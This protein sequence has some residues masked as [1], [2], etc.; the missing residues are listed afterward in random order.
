MVNPQGCSQ[1]ITRCAFFLLT[2]LLLSAVANAEP[3]IALSKKSGPPTSRILVSGRGFEANVGVDIFFDTKN[4]ALVVTN[5]K[6]EFHDAAINAPRSAHPGE[7]W[8]TALE[9]NNDT[10]ARAPFLVRTNWQQFQFDNDHSSVNPFENVISRMNVASLT[11]KWVYTSG[12]GLV[13][14]TPTVANGIAYVTAIGLYAVDTKTGAL[15]WS[16]EA[17]S[18]TFFCSPAVVDG[19]LYVASPDGYFYALNAD[20]GA[21]IWKV[22]G[23]SYNGDTAPAVSSGIVYYGGNQ[24]IYAVN[25]KTGKVVWT[26]PTGSYTR[27]AP[28]VVDGI[29][30]AGSNDGN[31][32]ALDARKG[33][34]VWRAAIGL[35]D[36]SSPAVAEGAVFVG[37]Y[38]GTFYALD[39]STG[40][41]LWSFPTTQN[42]E[43]SPLVNNGLV[44]V[45]SDESN[46]YALNA[47][48]GNVVWKYPLGGN[49]F[50]LLSLALA[51]N[52]LYLGY[53]S[54][55]AFDPTSGKLLWNSPAL[56]FGSP[57]V[58]DGVVYPSSFGGLAA[59]SLSRGARRGIKVVFSSRGEAASTAPSP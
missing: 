19:V 37:A 2:S 40:A 42:L 13:F 54:L 22:L 25:A 32:Y 57:I 49:S 41:T 51:N 35:I 36:N 20:T 4:K 18:Q 43:S 39:A 3:S 38:G 55:Y 17:G 16:F 28:A 8:V 12:E 5:G 50:N 21:V 47:S 29:V 31:L 46:L 45:L 59:F 1:A 58:A 15:L 34:L 7:H 11:Q 10:G 44:Y 14:S 52:V 26:Y 33:T 53:N 30:Y 23:T 9:R 27:S 24:T 48:N 56:G 6:G